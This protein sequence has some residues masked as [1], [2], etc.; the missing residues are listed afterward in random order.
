MNAIIQSTKADI[1]RAVDRAIV[2][3]RALDKSQRADLLHE[4][5][6]EIETSQGFHRLAVEIT[7]SAVKALL[8]VHE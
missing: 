7:R 4:C 8:K 6:D 1:E 3:C 5:D 2:K